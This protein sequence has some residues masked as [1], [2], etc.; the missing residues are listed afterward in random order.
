MIDESVFFAA[1]PS[2]GMHPT[3]DTLP[4]I[5]SNRSGRR[6]TP[7][8]GLLTLYKEGNMKSLILTLVL[9]MGQSSS[10]SGIKETQ[11]AKVE[12]PLSLRQVRQVERRME[13]LKAGMSSAEAFKALGI[14]KQRMKMPPAIWRG[15]R[16]MYTLRYAGAYGLTLYWQ[17]ESWQGESGSLRRAELSA[18]G[19]IIKVVD[20]R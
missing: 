1:P 7:G 20:L 12:G 18:E 15:A 10:P 19:K 13:N 3:A 6:V 16:T 4:V 14:L 11:D 5:S 2:N 9:F 8:V 17:P